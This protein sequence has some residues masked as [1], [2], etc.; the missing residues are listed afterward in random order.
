MIICSQYK[1][2]SFQSQLVLIV[3]DDIISKVMVTAILVVNDL[4]DDGNNDVTEWC[5]SEMIMI[6]IHTSLI[7]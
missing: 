3:I 6:M 7:I 1:L 5:D 2:I 4:H